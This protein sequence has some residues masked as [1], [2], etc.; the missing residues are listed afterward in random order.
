MGMHSNG[1]CAINVSLQGKVTRNVNSD[2][3]SY[4]SQSPWIL[5]STVKENIIFG[6]PLDEKRYKEVCA[7]ACLDLDLKN[8]PGG[9]QT[10]IG[11]RGI[12]LS[13]GQRQRVSVARALYAH[14]DLVILDD[15]LS[16]LDA[17]VGAKLFEKGIQKF[18]G[19]A[20]R[21]VVL[22]THHLQYLK[23]A[24]LVGLLLTFMH[25]ARRNLL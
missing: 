2:K 13:G 8:L 10:E 5:N 3:I 23:D 12:N 19:G 6:Q 21:T 24:D 7:A 20:D 9:D 15:P 22:I 17:H 11:E 14:S 16:A 4:A 1:Q 25:G 18:L